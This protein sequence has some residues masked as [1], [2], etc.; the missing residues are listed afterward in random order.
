MSKILDGKEVGKAVKSKVKAEALALKKKGII[1]KLAVLR[2]G[3]SQASIAYEN[4]AI[5]VMT[6]VGIATE[7]KTMPEEATTVDVLSVIDELN[8]DETVHGVIMMQPLPSHISRSELSSRL[9]P[10]KDVDALNPVNMGRLVE[11]DPRAMVPSTAKAVM[12]ILDY[13]GYNLKGA[14]VCVI[15][16]SPVV[17]KPLVHMLLNRFATV[18]NC[19]VYTKDNRVHSTRADIVISATGALGLVGPDYIKEGATVID[20][21]YGFKD[22][23]ACGD[24]R[25]D[26]VKDK[27]GAI[28]PVPGGVGSVTTAVLAVQTLKAVK[29]LHPEL[30]EA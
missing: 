22:G 13:Y 28:T 6:A 16:S 30:A 24:V 18:A 4:A 5:K 17:G 25:F 8:A 3:E 1:P 21:G 11:D 26:E 15:G 23:K 20:V 19:H 10:R 2:V 29:L 9:D 27:A 7:R 14:E 12:E